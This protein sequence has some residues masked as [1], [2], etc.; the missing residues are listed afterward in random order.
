MKMLMEMTRDACLHTMNKHPFCDVYFYNTVINLVITL[1]LVL[2]NG[3]QETT[4]D[5]FR[6]PSRYE[7]C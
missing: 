3:L 4:N 1:K 2:V 7:Q 5:I 6:V